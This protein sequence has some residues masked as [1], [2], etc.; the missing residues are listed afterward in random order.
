M[1]TELDED[2]AFEQGFQDVHADQPTQQTAAPAHNEPQA[3]ATQTADQAAAQTTAS[4]DDAAKTGEHT[5][6]EPVIDPFAALP[7]EVR[8]ILARVPQLEAELAQTRRVANMVPALQSRMDKLTQHAAA[9]GAPAKPRLE[10][11]AALRDQGLPEIADA[12][13]ELAA[14][15]MPQGRDDDAGA[16]GG[17]T[18][19][20]NT[21]DADP[22]QEMLDEL[23]PTWGDD[24]SSSDFQLW[25]AR[26]TPEYRQEVQSTG[27][28]TVILKALS[29][30]DAFRQQTGAPT[31]ASNLNPVQQVSAARSTRMAAAVTPQGD[32]RRQPRAI[33]DDEDAAFAAGFASVAGRKQR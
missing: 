29:T 1:N 26:Q 17:Q 27:K 24:L 32:G 10:R 33:E 25:L 19:H 7:K 28:A 3:Q 31:G 20:A 11:V 4:Q 23:R 9:S 6:A 22:Q 13:E 2:T 15:T 14:A 8:E 21:A 16:T 18:T 30:F 12:L 5:P